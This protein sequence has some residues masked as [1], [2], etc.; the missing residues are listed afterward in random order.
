MS[1]TLK[2][3]R[4]LVFFDQPQ[5]VELEDVL[6]C[7][8][9]GALVSTNNGMS[10]FAAVAVSRNR[11]NNF[12]KGTIDLL[13]VMSRPEDDER[14]YTVA[15]SDLDFEEG[16]TWEKAEQ[17]TGAFPDE[18]LPLPGLVVSVDNQDTVG[19]AKASA[20]L[21]LDA[22]LNDHSHPNRSSF[23]A[24]VVGGLMIE[25]QKSVRHSKANFLRT[26]TDRTKK[27]LYKGI[28][29]TV[30]YNHAFPGSLGLRF[31]IATIDRGLYPGEEAKLF[32]QKLFLVLSAND[33]DSMIAVLRESRGFLASSVIRT[34]RIASDANIDMTFRWA[35]PGDREPQT[36]FI[37][38]DLSRQVCN[39][40]LHDI[41][42]RQ[43]DVDLEGE[44]TKVDT[45]NGRW[46][47]LVDGKSIHGSVEEGH[48]NLLSHL[49]V[50][51][52]YIFHCTVTIEDASESRGVVEEKYVAISI[53][54]VGAE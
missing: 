45:N 33:S 3:S 22:L 29:T 31:T 30:E 35:S 4:V 52:F 41:T 2:I 19:A 32:T 27:T 36:R 9:L 16:L 43:Q 46:T 54:A 37:S 8:Y 6:G 15:T 50:N 26:V 13:E 48:Y 21:T 25:L 7:H 1:V 51:L 39:R 53:D 10:T 18:F 38:A 20:C 23:S 28:D 5:V 42:V 40:L 24:E 17:Y 34:L 44:L 49:E 14:M 11:L 12:Y 47:L